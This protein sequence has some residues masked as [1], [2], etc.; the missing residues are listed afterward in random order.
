MDQ[1]WALGEVQL[2]FDEVYQLFCSAFESELRMIGQRHTHCRKACRTFERCAWSCWTCPRPLAWDYDR[3]WFLEW[4]EDMR[5]AINTSVLRN[6]VACIEE[7]H[8]MYGAHHTAGFRCIHE[9]SG[10]NG[11]RQV[12]GS[13]WAQSAIWREWKH[14]HW[15]Q[16]K[17]A[18]GVLS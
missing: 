15:N 9:Q 14:R 2:A 16:S 3:Q 11:L 10:W 4:L 8:I 7:P 17:T 5:T 18:K 1:N 13:P 12:L 6:R